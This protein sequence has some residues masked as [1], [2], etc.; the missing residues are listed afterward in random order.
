MLGGQIR[1]SFCIMDHIGS[2]D[3]LV[4]VMGHFMVL[5]RGTLYFEECQ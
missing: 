3:I 5:V 2:V 1:G 4:T